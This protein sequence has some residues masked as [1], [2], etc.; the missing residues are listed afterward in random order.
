[1]LDNRLEPTIDNLYKAVHSGSINYTASVSAIDISGIQAQ[2]EGIIKEAGLS[3]NE[4][5][6]ADSKRRLAP[7]VQ[8]FQ[9]NINQFSKNRRKIS[10]LR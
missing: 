3:V 8:R 6:I 2:I 10:W 9:I 5:T 4:Q 7:A 1:M